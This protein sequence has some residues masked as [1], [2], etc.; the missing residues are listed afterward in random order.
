MMNNNSNMDME[1]VMISFLCINPDVIFNNSQQAGN[2]QQQHNL[3]NKTNIVIILMHKI[4]IIIIISIVYSN[5]F[6]PV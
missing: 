5:E 4:F 2:G 6:I 1:C 3:D